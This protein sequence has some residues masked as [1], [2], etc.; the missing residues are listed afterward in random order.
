VVPVPLKPPD[1]SWI[2]PIWMSSKTLH[3]SAYALFTCLCA[4]MLVPRRY[5]WLLIGILLGHA[6]L[7]EFAQYLTHDLFG[8][9]GQWSDV[10]L[11]TIGIAI[12]LAL[13]WPWWRAADVSKAPEPVSSSL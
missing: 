11:D 8:R 12:G 7:T 4:W 9:T 5:R 2:E 3:I 1:P 10:G 13:A 6:M